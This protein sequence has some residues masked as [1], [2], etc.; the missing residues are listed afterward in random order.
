MKG[1]RRARRNRATIPA[2]TSRLAIEMS[3]KPQWK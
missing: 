2:I 1:S 3:R